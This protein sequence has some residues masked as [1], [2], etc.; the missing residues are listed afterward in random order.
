MRSSLRARFAL[1][2]AGLVLVMG[3]VVALGGY[4]AMRDALLGRAEREAGNQARALAAMVESSPAQAASANVNLVDIRDPALVQQLL[5][6][7]YIVEVN[8]ANGALFHASAARGPRGPIR[9]PVGFVRNCLQTGGGRARLSAPDRALACERV[10]SRARLV[11]AVSVGV[12]L[13][14]SLGALATLRTALILG[15]LGGALLAGVLA[16]LLAGR[17]TRPIGQIARTAQAIRSGERP[18]QRIGYRGRDELGALAAVLDACFA[19][20]EEALERQ[21]R[22]GAD[23]SHELRTPL[24]AIRANIELLRGWAAAEPAARDAALASLDQ[25]ARRAA[26]LVEELLY[27]ATV[28]REPSRASAPVRLDEV[29]VAVVREATGLRGDVA[30]EISELDEM[31]VNGDALAL[32]Q[33]LLNLID[34]ALRVSPPHATVAIRLQ[35]HDGNATVSVSDQGS[36]IEPEELERIFDRFYTQRKNGEHRGGAGLGLAIARAIANDHRGKLTARNAATG[37]ATFTLTLPA[38][39]HAWKGPP[40][41]T[42]GHR[43]TRPT[44]LQAPAPPAQRDGTQ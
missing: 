26:R 31:T 7:G 32:Q 2:A 24:A 4:L 28:E 16:L 12:P 34:N 33:L 29:L 6:P 5:A 42:P 39:E 30:I 1:L 15:V 17:A 23:A 21:R 38:D 37:G 25:A 41:G 43:E 44:E 27:L 10:G 19:E 9:L 14:D 18:F 40:S 11:G 20:L 36:G 35:A 22:F 8:G 13:A 3:A